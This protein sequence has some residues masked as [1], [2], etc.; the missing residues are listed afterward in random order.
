M[1][2]M[3]YSS[4]WFRVSLV[5]LLWLSLVAIFFA[6]TLVSR[7]A[8][9]FGYAININYQLQ[10]DGSTTV[11][12]NYKVTNST[13][14]R[15]LASLK[16]NA[17]TDDVTDVTAV[18]ADG[19]RVPVQMTK[20]TTSS[21]GYTF[22]Y[23]E[24]NLTF[25]NWPSGK[26]VSQSFTLTYKTRSLIDVKGSSK[27]FSVPSLADI[28]P[29][30]NYAVSVTVPPKYGKLYSTGVLPDID[31][32]EGD[33]LRYTFPNSAELKRSISLIFGDTTVYKID[34]AYPLKNTTN[35]EQIFTVTLPPDTSG[36]KIFVNK[37]DPAPV[38]TRLDPDGNVLADY[39]VPANTTTVVH[40]DISAQ[41]KYLE[42][43]LDKGGSKSDIPTDIAKN[44][45]GSTQYWQTSDTA[46]AAKAKEAA[47][48]K[49]KVV[50]IVRSIH[51]L[52]KDTLTYN[53][54]KIKYNIRQGSTKALQ[55][56]E[57]AVCLE[58]SDLMIALLRSQGIPARMPVGY[59]YAGS[60]KQ[61][62]A[63]I[64]SLHSWVE[65]YI[66]GIGWINVDPTWG[67]KYDNFGKSDLDHVTFALWGRHDAAPGAVMI[68]DAD[69]NYQYE[70]TTVTYVETTPQVQ[71]QGKVVAHKYVLF[72]GIS[73]IQY[74]ATAPSQVAGDEYSIA[75][76]A[77]THRTLDPLGS[78]AP[79]QTVTRS[80]VSA[81]AGWSQPTE[82]LFQ[83]QDNGETLTLAAATATVTM[84]PMYVILG[85]IAG[86]FLLITLKL[87]IR[88][89]RLRAA[90]ATRRVD[91]LNHNQAATRSMH[92]A[93]TAAVT[94]KESTHEPDS[95]KS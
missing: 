10:N 55:N 64:D 8:N 87:V 42:Y 66:P 22:D 88:K 90:E 56:P 85:L 28:Q 29:D 86:T 65:A 91:E 78:L 58:Y 41:V 1:K 35:R 57:N 68:G 32:A 2:H 77:G 48:G 76:K 36:Q 4:R 6:G 31:G 69:Q 20:K 53:N 49:T 46:L 40:T 5:G 52:T 33:R 89:K 26:G 9:E 84:W 14:N 54:E 60:L 44:Y 30:E 82:L 12:T 25:A 63:V 50:D 72:P 73:Y 15:I 39:R 83:Q 27:T 59:A 13:S 94:A 70:D 92:A 18:Y 21:Q 17:P 81:G 67:E 74:E 51:Q 7:A 47:S 16:V 3:R 71:P 45:T 80:H 43:D 93:A 61:S 23:Q 11:V 62:K 79:G 24:M 95:T 37:L 19:S 75:S 34:F 38:S